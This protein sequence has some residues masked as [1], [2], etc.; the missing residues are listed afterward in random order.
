MNND[1]RSPPVKSAVVIITGGSSWVARDVAGG[2]AGWEWPIVLVYLDHQTLVEAAVGDIVAAGGTIVAVRADLADRF[3]VKRLFTEASAVFGDVD[4]VV[5]LTTEY[6]AL[7]YE[8]AALCV[9][10]HGA[11][12][13]TP[14]AR[15]IPPR[16]LSRLR[17]R[18]VTVG[19]VPLEGVLDFLDTW[20]HEIVD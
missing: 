10:E 19:R 5:H 7:L 12:V 9:R 3:D 13:C 4:V 8:E 20:G 2:L 16:V 17:E 15:P 14:P 1:S 6:A 11:I 18:A